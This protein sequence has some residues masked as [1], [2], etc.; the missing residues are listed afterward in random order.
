M[1]VSPALPISQTFDLPKSQSPVTNGH[2]KL[3]GMNPQGQRIAFTNLYMTRND[4]PCIPVM[5]EFHFSRYAHEYW[6]EELLKIK[7]GGVDIV[8]TYVF[9]NH[10]EEDEGHFDWAGN[11][12]LHE[13]VSLCGRH[14]LQS[15]VRIG[16]F[17]HGE[18]RNGGIPDWLYGRPFAV[19]SNDE[20]YLAYVHRLYG[21]I[22][23]QLDGLLFKD[24]GPVIGIQL[25]NEYMHAGAPWEVTFRQGTEWVPGGSDGAG[26]ILALKQI[27]LEVGLDVPL[28]TC[29]GWLGSPI[30]D[31]EVL[32]MQGGYF[33]TPWV[34]DPDFQ[35]P[36]TREFL[37]RDRRLHPVINGEPT[38]DPAQYPYACCEIGGGTQ[39]T[40]Y[41]RNPVPPEAVEGLA[42]MNLA[43]GANLIGYYMYHGGTNPVG[44]HSF[45][46]E[47][48]VP[49]R[50]YD[51]QAPV[52]EFGQI[53]DSYRSLRLLHLFLKDFGDL[54]APMQVSLP[55]NASAIAPEN[56]T[57]V[58]CAI[59]SKDGAGFLFLNSYQDHV[60]MHDHEGLRFE[61][62]DDKSAILIP[63]T[64]TLTLKKNL[65][66]IL[67]FG[68]TLNGVRLRSATTQ[69]LAKLVDNEVVNYFFFAPQAMVSEYVLETCSYVSLTVEGGEAVESEGVTVIVVT[70]GVHSLI[71]MTNQQGQI[72][73]LLT[74][75]RAQAEQTS[76]QTLWGKERLVISPAT[77]VAVGDACWV[78]SRE[79]EIDLIVYPELEAKLVSAGNAIPSSSDGLFTR[80]HL[81][82]P[83]KAVWLNVE[84]MNPDKALVSISP[85]SFEEVENIYLDVDYDGDI[86]NCFIDGKLV[87][88]NFY[89]GT[90]WE[91]GLKQVLQNQ[92]SKQLFILITPNRRISKPE[93]TTSSA[94]AYIPARS[95]SGAAAIQ[96][97][98]AVPEYKVILAVSAD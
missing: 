7:A 47:Y 84:P 92:T 87:S 64:Q 28:Y 70:P 24:G 6:E 77:I 38:Y 8:A 25:E 5:G 40:Y 67:P 53:A 35:Q 19:R 20:R 71:T 97:I 58:R 66:V 65:S 45:M 50:S 86:G 17:A 49:R 23:R 29:T 32:P 93:S 73:R 72:I 18:C 68:L 3:G 54:L 43:G 39:D 81:A 2:L 90:I 10:I 75:T 96:A 60:E 52:R 16:P 98:R 85:D 79:P 61:V 37:F 57:D 44:K 95:N 80:C 14:N 55:G 56:T 4:Q 62:R 48:T 82:L 59:R 26:H 91:L 36:P 30:P 34:P 33:F 31:G 42:F 21:E 74:L 9:W 94:M 12:N 41:H 46:N 22:A 27:A 76:K 1:Q 69:L 51:F 78:Y 88:D 11:N 63:Q 89:N 13:F 83:P 15:I